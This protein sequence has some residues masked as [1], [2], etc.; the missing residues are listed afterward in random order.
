MTIELYHLP[1]FPKVKVQYFGSIRAAAIKPEEEVGCAPNTSVY[2][3]LQKL[4][5]IYGEGFRGELFEE[6]GEGFR[7]DLMVMLNGTIIERTSAA[8][9]NLKGGDVLALF[10]LFLGGG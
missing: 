5:G 6:S 7:R 10:P 9:I 3:L 8:N 2:Q 4:T 1:N